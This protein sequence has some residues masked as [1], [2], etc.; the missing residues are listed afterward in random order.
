MTF[1]LLLLGIVLGVLAYLLATPDGLQKL[2]HGV[3]GLL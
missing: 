2:V 3:L 1:R